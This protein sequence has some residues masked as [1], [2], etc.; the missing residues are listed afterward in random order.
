M[1]PY[2]MAPPPRWW[3]PALKPRLVR[4]LRWLRRR[5]RVR[6]MRLMEIE[7]EGSEHVQHALAEGQGVLITPN[8]A[9]HADPDTMYAA[10]DHLR[11]PFYF[12][13]TWHVFASHSLI[14]RRV[15]QWHGVFSVDREGADLRAFKQAV[16]ILQ[17]EPHPLVIFPEGEVYH[18]NDRVTPFREGAA[19]VALSA[20]KRAK[21]PI[22]CVPCA[23]KYRY[24][25]DPMDELLPLMDE[26]ERYI[27]WRPRPD[28]PLDERIYKF[29]EA[30]LALKE[31]EFLGRASAGSLP[32]RTDALAGEILR[33]LEERHGVDPG[34]S[35]IPERVKE[36]RHISLVR[37]EDV[38]ADDPQ[39]RQLN[40]DLDDLF[41]VVQLFSYPGDY[42]AERPSIERMAETLE[43]F[44]ED[45]LGKY[46]ATVR[47]TRR[48]TVRF[49]Q[50]VAVQ[51]GR[52][53]KAAARKLIGTLECRVQEMWTAWGRR[54]ANGRP[55]A[56]CRT[57]R[58]SVLPKKSGVAAGYLLCTAVSMDRPLVADTHAHA[59][60][61]GENPVEGF[62]SKRSRSGWPTRWLLWSSGIRRERG[63]TLSDKM[64]NRLLRQVADSQMDYVVVLAQDAVYWEDGS[65]DD[66]ATDFFV[67]NRYVLELAERSPKVLAGCSINPIRK[68][69]LA[70]LDRCYAAGWSRSTRPSRASIRR[71]RDSTR[72][73]GLPGSWASC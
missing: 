60:C 13:S 21:R 38:K 45:V 55:R 66:A 29:A 33:R 58:R 11:C 48:V 34:D 52:E 27:Y 2:R 4:M 51:A 43:K 15:L 22:V 31:M 73:T 7:V 70:E 41:L 63:E 17:G 24:I 72:S 37:L 14:A 54:G 67:S 69:A 18:C 46:S 5:R 68:D 36:M 50:P 12:M 26:L 32:E 53:R 39:Y 16:K 9:S 62:L 35:T 10:A 59:F 8:H 3:G 6:V 40:D 42:V 25:E 64:R 47:S 19:V 49:G 1:N 20:A 71:G 65:R 44:E 57:D 61:W 56:R 23:L 28:R 30:A